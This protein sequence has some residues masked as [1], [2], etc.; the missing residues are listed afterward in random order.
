MVNAIWTGIVGG[1]DPHVLTNKKNDDETSR[2]N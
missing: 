1:F 2:K